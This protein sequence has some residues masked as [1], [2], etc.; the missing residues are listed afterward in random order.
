[1]LINTKLN[2]KA[3]E[4][5]W[6]ESIHMYKHVRNTMY[7]TVNTTSPFKKIYGEKPK[8]FGSISE[9]GRIGYITKRYK[10]RKQMIYKTF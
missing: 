8:I 10:F 4:M 5:L 6:K 7:T 3:Q 1:M 9:F 2:E